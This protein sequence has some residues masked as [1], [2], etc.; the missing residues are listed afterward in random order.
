MFNINFVMMKPLVIIIG[1]ILIIHLS[2]SAQVDPVKQD[3]KIYKKIGTCELKADV[4][5]T[6]PACFG[7]TLPTPL[8]GKHVFYKNAFGHK[9]HAVFCHNETKNYSTICRKTA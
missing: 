3:E 1:V 7:Y 8:L 4:F 2:V 5:Y 9:V 6:T